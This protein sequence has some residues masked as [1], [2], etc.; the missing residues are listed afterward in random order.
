MYADRNTW[1]ILQMH[2]CSRVGYIIPGKMDVS[3]TDSEVL[4]SSARLSATLRRESV[5]GY[6]FH[7]ENTPTGGIDEHPSAS[8]RI[9][10][11]T[12]DEVCITGISPTLSI[13][14]YSTN[15]TEVFPQISRQD[16]STRIRLASLSPGIYLISLPN[17]DIP[18]I[19]II[20]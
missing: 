7:Y 9:A 17:T 6:S 11:I 1:L 20:H 2:N 10:Y 4:L 15:G 8:V 18:S 12:D 3:F 16:D 14:V 5:A 13:R 19:K